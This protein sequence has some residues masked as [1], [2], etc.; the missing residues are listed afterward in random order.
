MIL[1]CLRMLSSRKAFLWGVVMRLGSL[2]RY[3]GSARK[4]GT[5]ER[6]SSEL[7]AAFEAGTVFDTH[8]RMAAGLDLVLGPLAGLL[9]AK[10][11]G[12]A[13]SEREAIAAFN[14]EAFTPELPKAL[15]LFA[16]D[17]P[18]ERHASD[19]AAALREM[20]ARG[21]AGSAA[22]RYVARIAPLVTH[23]AERSRPTYEWL[24][25]WVGQLD[26]GA[27]KGR[28]FAARPVR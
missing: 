11:A 4:G 24:Y 17:R 25:A 20:A 22:A 1:T 27:S 19:V 14:E 2:A 18:T 13:E 28:E 21:G 23:A 26:L 5:P 16:W 10:W 12:Y 9:I 7:L 6:L 3:K 8:G 15:K